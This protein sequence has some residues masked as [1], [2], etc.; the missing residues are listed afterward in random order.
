M[1]E[2]CK[3][4]RHWKRHTPHIVLGLC[5]QEEHN[6][7]ICPEGFGCNRYEQKAPTEYRPGN[8]PFWASINDDEYS[9]SIHGMIEIGEGTFGIYN[10]PQA[11]VLVDRLN[12]ACRKWSAG[13]SVTAGTGPIRWGGYYCCVTSAVQD[14]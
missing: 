10:L 5:Q 12:S 14:K 4:C 8:G 9:W 1:T 6:V 7:G 13:D 2:T 11:K 3:T